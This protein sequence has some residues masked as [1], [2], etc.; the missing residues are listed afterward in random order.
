[1]AARISGS[2]SCT[3]QA[4]AGNWGSQG[5][6]PVV[7]TGGPLLCACVQ[8][9]VHLHRPLEDV[10]ALTSPLSSCLLQIPLCWFTRIDL[11]PLSPEM[12]MFFVD[13]III[14]DTN[15]TG[16]YQ[17]LLSSMNYPSD[18]VF[19]LFWRG[20]FSFNGERTDDSP[21]PPQSQGEK[22]VVIVCLWL[23][24]PSSKF[25]LFSVIYPSVCSCF[26]YLSSYPDFTTFCLRGLG[27][28]IYKMG[29]MRPLPHGITVKIN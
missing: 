11:L 14:A 28:L 19:R 25:L 5:E 10:C 9:A 7:P 6:R 13:E 29:I 23:F 18:R 8:L 21:L 20:C 2:P 4:Q 26:G 16:D 27:F 24:Y 3:V 15:L 22:E 1:M 17:I 12:G